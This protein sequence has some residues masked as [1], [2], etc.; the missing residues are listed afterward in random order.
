MYPILP[1]SV[2][3]RGGVPF[4][5]LKLLSPY[6]VHYRMARPAP[7]V[8]C[9]RCTNSTIEF[10]TLEFTHKLHYFFL[11]FTA[12]FKFL[13]KLTTYIMTEL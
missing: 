7:S 10:S 6:F 9:S 11:N 13:A 2:L 5:L 1:L 3:A 12:V 8:R 4:E